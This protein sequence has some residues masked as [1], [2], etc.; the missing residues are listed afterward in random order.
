[1][2]YE[3]IAAQNLLLFSYRAAKAKPTFTISGLLIIHKLQT[4][5][6]NTETQAKMYIHFEH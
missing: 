4:E 6:F 3:N 2:V 1:M 5:R